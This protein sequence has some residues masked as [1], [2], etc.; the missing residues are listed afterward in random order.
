MDVRERD[1]RQRS[2]RADEPPPRAAPA[3]LQRP[4]RERQERRDRPAQVPGALR[5]AVRL[6]RED[7]PAERRR[8]G[9]QRVARAATGKRTRPPRGRSAAGTGSTRAR[10]RT[11]RRAARRPRPNGQPPKFQRG[12][13][14]G[15]KVYGSRHGACAIRELVP[16]EPEV[17]LGLQVVACR[18]LAG[19]R[20][21]AREEAR[22]RVR[23]LRRHRDE[24]G[25]EV[26][27]DE[28]RYKA[29]AAESSSSKSGTSAASY[30][31]APR[32]VPL[33]VDQEGRPLGDVLEA[34]EVMRDP[35]GVYRLARSSPRAAGSSGRAP[36]SRRRASRASPARPRPVARPPART[37]RSCHAG[38][39]AHPFK[40]RTNRTGRRASR[41]GLSAASSRREIRSRG[42]IQTCAS[43]NCCPTSSIGRAYGTDRAST[44]FAFRRAVAGRDV[45]GGKLDHEGGRARELPPLPAGC[46]PARRGQPAVGQA[47]QPGVALQHGDVRIGAVDLGE[48]LVVPD[49]QL[50]LDPQDEGAHCP[51][52]RLRHRPRSRVVAVPGD[53]VVHPGGRPVAVQVDAV[54]V[55][56]R[57]R[58][59]P[60]RV[61]GR[62][63]PEVDVR[64][65]RQPPQL[66]DHRQAGGLAAVD[67]ADDERRR[68]GAVAALV[69][70]DR[71]APH[72][73][74]DHVACGAARRAPRPRAPRRSAPAAPVLDAR[75]ASELH[76]DPRCPHDTARRLR[77]NEHPLVGGRPRHEQPAVRPATARPGRRRPCRETRRGRPSTTSLWPPWRRMVAVSAPKRPSCDRAGRRFRRPATSRSRPAET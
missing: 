37:P 45:S 1:R 52:L 14:S 33:S 42:P 57:A 76:R 11:A 35:E 77:P 12:G 39:P 13:L 9:R 43:G 47:A 53:A 56:A 60:V 31:H 21:P 36:A 19:N 30:R 55:L 65:Q 59:E 61:D 51:V 25:A 64:R 68:R 28:E 7:E 3:A 29:R 67:H 40:S 71:P 58:G 23:E 2:A 54:R 34:A 62:H 27:R 18:R 6:E 74:A 48:R 66:R 49:R 26:E 46:G 15:R 63:E 16:D 17:V 69:G 50:R 10:D 72:G 20:C 38:A 32:T 75:K 24:A 4:E 73:V 22:A 41:S 70:H 8:R 44:A 5:D